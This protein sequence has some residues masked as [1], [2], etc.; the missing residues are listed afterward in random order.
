[1]RHLPRT[2]ECLVKLDAEQGDAPDG[3]SAALQGQ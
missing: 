2:T 3:Y 1:M